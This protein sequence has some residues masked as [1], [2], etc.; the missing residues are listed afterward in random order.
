MSKNSGSP[1][2]V[3]KGLAWCHEQ[4]YSFYVPIDWQRV[5]REDNKQGIIYLPDPNDPHTYFAVQVDDL[6]THIAQ[7]DVPDLMTG[8]LDGISHRAESHVDFHDQHSVGKLVTLEAKYSFREADERRKRWVRILYHESRQV[9]FIA[10]GKTEQDYQY[11]LPMFNEAMM[12]LKVH[13]TKP[14]IP[15]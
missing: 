10:Q 6:G 3:F 4:Y 12:T 5:E 9:T 15:G 1:R 14:T 13:N 11:W 8:L 2:P 7:S